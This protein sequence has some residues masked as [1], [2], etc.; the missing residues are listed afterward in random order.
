[1]AENDVATYNNPIEKRDDL[2]TDAS[3][4]A[5]FWLQQLKLAE[6][7]DR[8]F[9]QSGRAIVKRYRDERREQ[10]G[11]AGSRRSGSPARFN[12]LWSNVETLKPILY[13]RTP[14]PD[15]QRRHKNA[16]DDPITVMGADILERA[17]AYEDDLDEFN[18]VMEQVVEDRLLPGRGVARVFYE[19]SFGEPEDDPDGEE[20]EDGRKLTFRP[21][22]G[23]R[24]PIKYVFWEDFR[25][26]PAR[27]QDQ[28]WWQAFRSYLTRD[29]LVERF[30]KKIGN[31]VVL[32]YTPKGLDEDGLK[33]PQADAFKKAMV[34][35][36][37]DKQKKKAVWVAPSYPD[38]P[39]DTKDDP[40]GLPGFFPAPRPLSATT[41]NETLVP[42]ADYSEY[43]DQAIE[44]DILTGRIDKLTTALKVVGL[45]AGEDKAVI[46]Q[47]FSEDGVENQLIPVEG[48]AL[49][50]EKGGLQN[51]IVWA[52][53]EQIA[54]VL[55]QL[56][57]ARERV[58]R[59]LY[60]ITGMADILR[61]ETNPNETLGAQQLKAQFA[62]RRITRS[63]KQVARFA[64]DL[65][66]LRAHVMAKHFS[67]QTLS[68]MVGLPERL[69]KMPPMP[70]M[71]V[72]A[73]SPQ[74]MPQQGPPGM[75]PMMGHNGGPP[76]Q[77]GIP[78]PPQVAPGSGGA[79]P[80][81]APPPP[82]PG[83]RLAPDGRHYLPDPRRPGKFLMVA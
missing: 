43:E 68:Q 12:I 40:L 22:T 82:V 20:D 48:W 24:A 5:R 41:T 37:W 45:Y 42:R 25:Q 13:G 64:R 55:I 38:G 39:L 1:M 83:A 30:G 51:A 75:P 57:D 81:P 26:S 8:R 56:Y 70:P 67:V 61:G 53:M 14:K 71:I 69:P 77:P 74:M 49:F 23:E 80:S 46:S 6:R 79:A 34:W 9:V 2:G 72:P 62:T 35:E 7:E 78:Q 31:D 33:G 58:K 11:F 27:T 17:L 44:L 10:M 32:D 28:V 76:M 73:P 4:V 54:K 21:V 63:Q 66:R 47:M 65:M 50:M 19:P 59:T 16:D 36:I 29:E 3:A 60:E 15:V 52:P 18:E